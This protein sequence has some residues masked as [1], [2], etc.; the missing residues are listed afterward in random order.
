MPRAFK[1]FA[2][3]LALCAGLALASAAGVAQDVAASAEP[4]A[5]APAPLKKLRAQSP[6]PGSAAYPAEL[7]SQGV[8]G[9]TDVLVA[10]GADG[11]PA[12]VSVHASSGS[13]ALD[14]LALGFVRGLRFRV[15]GA[16]TGAPPRDVILPVEFLRDSV[17]GLQ[18]KRCADFNVD[19]AYFRATFPD[20]DP[21]RMPVIRMTTGMLLLTGVSRGGDAMVA[22]ARQ[23]AAAAKGIATACQAAPDANYLQTFV[24][25]LKQAG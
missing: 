20:T 3:R 15:P 11:A 9:T 18:A 7:A 2:A 4:A 8:Q 22:M 13:A 6:L 10:I 24:G 5:S 12:A 19:A 21:S 17:E 25:L 14:E 23:L 1:S 16:A